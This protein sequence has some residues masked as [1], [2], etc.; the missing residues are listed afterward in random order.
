M[1]Q[2]KV[3]EKIR[4]KWLLRLDADDEEKPKAKKHSAYST[5]LP[6]GLCNSEGINTEGMTP[7]EAWE[8]YEN[9][10]GK[11][12]ESVKA[13][14]MGK[15]IDTGKSVDTSEYT[16]AYQDAVKE[17]SSFEIK[18]AVRKSL[19]EMPTGYTAVSHDRAYKKIGDDQFEYEASN[20]EKKVATAKQILKA[21]GRSDIE[22]DFE[23]KDDKYVHQKKQVKS[24]LTEKLRPNRDDYEYED[25]DSVDD[26]TTKNVGKLMPLYEEG[27][28]DAIDSEFYKFKLG[29]VTKNLHEISRDEADE[30]LYDNLSQSTIDGWFRAYNHE[31]KDNLTKQMIQSPEVHNAALNIM[32]GNY[33]YDCE[34]KK[35]EPLSFDE[36]LV[37]P[38]KMYRGGTGKEYEKASVFSSYTFD[39]DVAGSFT[40]S[41]VGMGHAPDPNGVIYEAEI[42]PI[43]TYGSVFTN[44]EAEILVPREI[45]PNGRRDEADVLARG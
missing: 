39:R 11:S 22:G 20:G 6:Y 19:E 34:A 25:G 3:V 16:K 9:K 13:E 31:Y 33:K 30:I 7:R 29:K 15:G 42:R 4:L 1:N 26:F 23:V 10:T 35:K 21:H 45:A 36:F 17:K 38:I 2:A 8:A 27:G 41:E 32:Y 43:D 12:A 14:K 18:D 40:G 24:D 5:Q 28:S 37:T 44:G